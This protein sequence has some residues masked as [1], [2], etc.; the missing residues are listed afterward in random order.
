MAQD[1][2]ILDRA[3]RAWEKAQLLYA[4]P[5]RSFEEPEAVVLAERIAD[6]Y[7]QFHDDLIDLLSS[8]R[9][10][11]VAYALMTLR[12]MRSPFL[13]DLPEELLNRRGQVTISVGSV[14]NSMDLGGLARQYRKEARRPRGRSQIEG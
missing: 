7:P 3:V 8:T 14:R 10:L 4:A 5:V 6:E 13:A 11:V 1:E 2:T 9:T 12:K